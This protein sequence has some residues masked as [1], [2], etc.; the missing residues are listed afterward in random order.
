M[1]KGNR[2]SNLVRLPGPPSRRPHLAPLARLAVAAA[3]GLL[4]A[5]LSVPTVYA[6]ASAQP[7]AGAPEQAKSELQEVVVTGSRRALISVLDSPSPVDII[8]SNA[9]AAHASADLNDIL[10]EEV[11]SFNVNDNAI[12]GTST[13]ERP[14][15]LRGLSPDHVLVLVGGK[16]YHRAGNIGTFSGSITDGAQGPDLGSLPMTAFK[17]IQVLRDGAGATYGADAIAGVINFI[18]DDSLGGYVSVKGGRTYSAD[19]GNAEIDAAYGV[20]LG[21]QTGF[22]RLSV[23]YGFSDATDRSVPLS[24]FATDNAA[25][26]GPS[27]HSPRMGAP[28]VWEDLKVFL[29]TEVPV[30]PSATLYGFGGFSHRKTSSDFFDRDPLSN[31]G[32]F[33]FTDPAG[34]EAFLVG[35]LNPGVGPNCPG[36]YDPATGTVPNPIEVN[37]PNSTALFRQALTN[38]KCFSFLQKYPGGYVPLF[39]SYVTDIFGTGGLRGTLPNGLHYD[40]SFGAGRNA[41]TFNIQNSVNPSMGPQSPSDFGDLGTRSQLEEVANLDLTYPIDVH[42]FASPLTVAGGLE[43]HHE[44]FQVIA[45]Q[46]EGFAVGPLAIQGFAPF[47]EAFTGFSNLDAGTFGRSDF[48]EYLDLSADVSKSLSLDVAARDENFSDVGNQATWKAAALF[49][50]TPSLAFRATYA[51]G[52][53]APSPGEQHFRAIGDFIG[54]GGQLFSTGLLPSS[55]PVVQAVGGAP[56]RPETARSISAGF[57]VDSRLLTATL[58]SYVIYMHHRLTTSDL[59]QLTAAQRAALIAEG[60]AEAQTITF[61]NFFTNSFSTKT[62]GTDLT[63][64]I[65]LQFIDRGTTTFNLRGNF[66]FTKVIEAPLFIPGEARLVQT[67]Y[68]IPKWHGVT[69]VT[70]REGNW[71]ATLRASYWGKYVECHVNNCALRIDAADRVTLDL[72]AAYQLTRSLEVRAGVDNFLNRFP[73]RNP[74]GQFTGAAY[75][76]VNPYGNDGGVYYA[77]L[78]YSF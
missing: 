76:L 53:H 59:F 6:Q 49:H 14:A 15:V 41:V 39:G 35:D 32:L 72:E 31:D 73:T 71:E 43:W 77:R 45:G 19:G 44:E 20:Q 1:R 8:G 63:G 66:N 36:G 4:G 75:P 37:A 78:R 3:M 65:P 51:T 30:S 69:W 48:A 55:S 67:Q 57:V 40:L 13:T 9:L 34:N 2:V 46:P 10:R 38:P 5:L 7:T 18:P 47:Q 23:E 61:F 60:V 33:T 58:D 25:G 11:P 54:S 52:F 27:P 26:F 16:R 22:A 29:N 68:Q 24:S 17:S 21:P 70:H 62:Y 74:Y 64:R 42:F 56:L 12:S 28:R 50:I